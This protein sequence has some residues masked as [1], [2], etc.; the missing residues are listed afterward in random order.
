MKD[1]YN[2]CIFSII[3]VSYV[4]QLYFVEAYVHLQTATMILYK[5]Y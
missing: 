2:H 3:N 5:I 4:T 1:I